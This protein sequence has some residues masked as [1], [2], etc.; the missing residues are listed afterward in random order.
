MNGHQEK[1][2]GHGGTSFVAQIG[3]AKFA[4]RS[5]TFDDEKV[6]GGQ[7]AEAAGAHPVENFVIL[8][9]LPSFELESLRPQETV[10]LSKVS[11]FYVIEGDETFRFFVDGLS[12]EW[13][14]KKLSGKGIKTLVGKDGENVEVLQEL[15]SVPDRVIGDDD[16]VNLG[17]AG[18]ERFK[19]RKKG[20]T[21]YVEGT[22]HPWD[23]P[24]ISYAEIVTLEFPTYPQ[25]PEI[26]YT[27]TFTKGPP[28]KP[29]GDVAKGES[30][31]VHDGM[32]FHVSPT[33]ES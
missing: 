13:P 17:E 15:E 20:V 12:L 28:N 8:A 6:T 9:Q 3:D 21:I 25:H 22:P 27:V 2:A 32:N 7:V 29:V 33:G 31:R 10:D 24:K 30:T 14:K 16:E 5:V 23:K 4:F 18:V 19:T 11:R 1:G 26:P